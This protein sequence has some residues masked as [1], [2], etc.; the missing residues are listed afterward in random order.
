MKKKSFPVI[1]WGLLLFLSAF[2]AG[3]ENNKKEEARALQNELDTDD[4]NIPVFNKDSAYH[5]V[6]Q[7]VNFG[8]RVPNTIAHEKTADYLIQKLRQY[9]AIV[10]VQEF[11]ATTFDNNELQ[12]KN[13]IAS[14]YPEKKKR[15]LLAA[16]WDT[17]PFADKDSDELKRSEPI[18]GAND[19]A[20]GVGLLLEI[21][22][23]L[24][25]ADTEPDVGVD[26]IFFD[27]EDWGE[28]EGM[29]RTTPNSDL[30]EDWWAL[31]SQ[32]WSKN[33]HNPSYSAYY[34]ILLDMVGA[35]NS[36][37]YQEGVSLQYAPSIVRK[38]WN[39]AETLGYGHIFI[40]KKQAGITDDHL[41]VNEY[42]KIPM[43]NIVHYDSKAGYFGD[44]HHT[45]KDNMDII[46]K[47]IL[48]AVGKT[49]LL[50][51]YKEKG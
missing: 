28:L 50:T 7:Q 17:R 27:G 45:H 2:S 40:D 4:L 41:F 37:F 23:N 34:G 30:Y 49:V 35:K 14:F 48:E 25:S 18:L 31:G 5:F 15:I 19:G 32:Y 16:H 46:S 20:S 3:C 22:R 6:A 44:Y 42:A 9:G 8:P 21:A 39:N 26:I 47:E 13:I 11:S 12:L 51:I 1:W 38:V 29:K 10:E 36:T 43:I 24:H 33:K